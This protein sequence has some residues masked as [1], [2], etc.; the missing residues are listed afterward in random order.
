MKI[1]CV[2]G[3]YQYG[4]KERGINTEYF[5]FIPAFE[6]LGHEV[7]FFD[8]WDKSLY[9]DFIEL[10]DSLIKCVASSSPDI[11]FS[12]QLG[13]EI[14]LETWDYIRYNFAVKTINWCT[15]DSWKYVQHSKFL[16][17]HFDL[18]VTTYEEFLHEYEKQKVNVILTTWAVPIQW[19]LKPKKAKE[20]KYQVT[21]I[22]AAHGDR[23]E[24]IRKLKDSGI[25]IECFGYGWANGPLDAEKI[26]Q[27]FNNSI[28]NLNFANSS[29]EN[30]I[31]ARVFEVT[32]SGGF[33]LTENAKNLNSYFNNNEIIIFDDMDDC[34]DKINYY[35]DNLD[36]RDFI[37][38]KSFNKTAN[39]FTYVNKLSKI[40]EYVQE[41]EKTNLINNNFTSVKEEHK[42]TYILKFLKNLLICIASVIFGKEKGKRFA[43]R[44]TF[45]LSWRIF[46]ESTFKAKGIVGRMFYYE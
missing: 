4:K 15:D 31:K 11:I 7:I 2:F 17:K 18:M 37:V 14:W 8:S 24:K 34:I 9:A 20:C 19:I 35:L 6:E 21:F 26:P 40:L 13:Y 23:K 39:K 22:G 28:I 45:E 44:M 29:G 30:Q 38:E 41:I 36:K 10:N 43:R 46:K 3:K 42:K 25:N 16:A 1:L 33:L 12:V 5:S 32:G 27:I